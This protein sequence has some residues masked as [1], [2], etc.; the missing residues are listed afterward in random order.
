MPRGRTFDEGQVLDSAMHAFRRNGYAGVSIKQLEQATGL[1][2]GSLYNAYGDKDGLFRAAL[3]HYVESF[4]RARIA[5][6][7]GAGATVEDLEALFLSVLQAPMNDGFG[8]LVTNSVVE[9]GAGASV[10]SGGVDLALATVEAGVRSVLTRE[11]G[12]ESAETA[13]GRLLLLYQGLLVLSR[14]G[15]TQSAEAAIRSE[16]DRLK[17]ERAASAAEEELKPC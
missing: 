11:L 5:S 8:C 9:F 10:A 2:S 12:P 13:V 6:H 7:A 15:R 14:A 3:G 17:R 1:T 4:V 16:F